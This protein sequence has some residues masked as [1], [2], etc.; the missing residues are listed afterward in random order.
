MINY[1]GRVKEWLRDKGKV[2]VVITLR[3]HERDLIRSR[4]KAD[5]TGKMGGRRRRCGVTLLNKVTE[6]ERNGL[7]QSDRRYEE[8]RRSDSLKRYK[9][10]FDFLCPKLLAP[11]NNLTGS[12]LRLAPDN[13][14]NTLSARTVR[15][16]EAAERQVQ[17]ESRIENHLPLTNLKTDHSWKVNVF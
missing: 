8:D 3:H 1:V 5:G 17:R 13:D 14:H 11:Q 4:W 15:Q 7:R 10:V 12:E 16:V 9:V 2:C 6:G